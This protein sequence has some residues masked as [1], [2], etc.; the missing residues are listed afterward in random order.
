MAKEAGFVS[1]E[2][3]S[4]LEKCSAAE[5]QSILEIFET[6]P[7]EDKFTA[8]EV[9]SSDRLSVRSETNA[10]CAKQKPEDLLENAAVALNACEPASGERPAAAPAIAHEEVS[11]HTETASSE[12]EQPSVAPTIAH[13]EVSA[14]AS[15][16]EQPPVAPAIAHEDVSARTETASSGVEQ[17]PVAAAIAHEEVSTQRKTASYEVDQPSVAPATTR[18]EPPQQLPEGWKK[19]RDPTGEV[20]YFNPETGAASSEMLQPLASDWEVKPQPET[21]KVTYHNS[22]T[23][24]MDCTKDYHSLEQVVPTLDEQAMATVDMALE[25]AVKDHLTSQMVAAP[26]GVAFDDAKDDH[27]AVHEV[28]N[29]EIAERP[30]LAPEIAPTEVTSLEVAEQPC[31]A[32]EI[33]PGVATVQPFTSTI[34]EP[35]QACLDVKD[36]A[37]CEDCLAHIYDDGMASGKPTKEPKTE[38]RDK[39]FD[40]GTQLTERSTGSEEQ[41]HEIGPSSAPKI[42]KVACAVD[43]AESAQN[44]TAVAEED[45]DLC[46]LMDICSP[47]TP[48]QVPADPPREQERESSMEPLQVSPVSPTAAKLLHGSGTE[49]LKEVNRLSAGFVPNDGYLPS[50][51]ASKSAEVAALQAKL[52]S[53]HS[54]LAKQDEILNKQGMQLEVAV[55]HMQQKRS[56]LEFQQHQLEERM[57]ENLALEETCMVLNTRYARLCEQ[58]EREALALQ[59]RPDSTTSLSSVPIQGPGG[60]ARA[61]REKPRSSSVSAMYN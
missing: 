16:V 53:L 22:V 15:G 61:R 39:V 7:C 56:D 49:V 24:E 55:H 38:S 57:C 54:G 20:R 44:V 25:N 42:L 51:L 37:P 2:I 45:L 27:T 28:T 46:T 58:V 17:P 36:L 35:C 41:P 11:T 19:T 34:V 48:Q 18:P 52:A 23:G 31:V 1:S 5:L 40:S 6:K 26:G 59:E 4:L 14:H 60:L 12:V 29:V 10:T 21:G 33:M 32:A 47:T 3:A 13:E 50:L 30:C 8:G 43:D 9:A